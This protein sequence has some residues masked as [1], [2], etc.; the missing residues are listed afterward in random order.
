MKVAC[1]F[2]PWYARESP[3]PEFA[4]MIALVKERGHRVFIFDINNEIFSQKFDKRGYW[5]YFLL[6]VPKEIEDSFFFEMEETFRHYCSEILSRKP[7]IIIFKPVANTYNNAIYLAEILKRENTDRLII[8][9]GKYSINEQDIEYLMRKQKDLP[10]DF[11][12]CGQDEIALPRLL[13]AIE[14]NNLPNFDLSFKR[15]GKVVNCIEGPILDNLDKLPFFDFSDFDLSSYK[16]P[17]KLEIFTSRGCPWRCSFCISWMDEY[18]YRSMSGKRILQEI[19]Y[20][21][22][23]HSNVKHFRFCDM[24]INGNIPA[25]RDFC[26]LILQEY[27]KGL[28]KIEWSGD[29]IIRPEFTEEFLLKMHDAG[30]VGIGYGLESGSS[31]VIKDMFKPYSIPLAE[32]VIRDTHRAAIK[33]SVNIMVGFPT[34]THSDFKQT[35][36]FIEKNKENIDEIRLTFTGCRIYPDSYVY[37]NYKKFGIIA[38]DIDNWTSNDGLNTYNERLKRAEEVCQLVLSLGIKLM[39]NSRPTKKSDLVKYK[40]QD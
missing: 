24:T 39:V 31:R 34:E 19:L 26:E 38:L 35:L 30:C 13:E 1:V 40:L 21:L 7:D 23:F 33:T 25:L 15:K 17:E 20:Q 14:T 9:S 4:S 37:K 10:F 18:K 12:I 32:R 28:P 22:N 2:T 29:A 27:K 36:K 3:F 16:Y 11:I 5:K 6:D 8:F